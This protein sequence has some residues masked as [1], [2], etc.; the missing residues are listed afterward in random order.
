MGVRGADAADA[1]AAAAVGY[2]VP[3]Q[4]ISWAWVK[5]YSVWKYEAILFFLC[6]ATN[7]QKINW[8]TAHIP[9]NLGTPLHSTHLK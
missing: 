2:P 7:K 8:Y 3:V 5:M 6:P 1:A 9:P 4:L